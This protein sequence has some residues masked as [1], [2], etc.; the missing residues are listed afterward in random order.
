MLGALAYILAWVTAFRVL[1]PFDTGTS[2]RGE[3][4]G[5]RC[6]CKFKF[7]TCCVWSASRAPSW[8]Y[9]S[10]APRKR[11]DYK[12]TIIDH[13]LWVSSQC[14]SYG[15]S[16]ER[17]CPA[18]RAEW[19]GQGGSP[20]DHQQPQGGQAEFPGKEPEEEQGIKKEENQQRVMP[21]NNGN[22]WR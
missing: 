8:I 3:R 18:E 16:G 19:G 9:G 20:A 7:S 15:Q 21:W 1:F 4:G 2:G 14:D 11:L 22:K 6:V 12:L 13:K 10:G 17:Y 5:A